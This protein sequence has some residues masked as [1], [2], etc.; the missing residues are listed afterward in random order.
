MFICPT[1]SQGYEN[2]AKFV[3][4]YLFCWKKHNPQQK[5]KPAPRS[6]TIETKTINEELQTFFERRN[7]NDRNS[8]N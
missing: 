5:S 6:A 4:H 7:P 2:E 1:C 3:K 8:C